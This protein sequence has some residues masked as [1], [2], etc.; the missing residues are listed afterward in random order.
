MVLYD[1]VPQGVLKEKQKVKV[2]TAIFI[3]YI[4]SGAI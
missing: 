2:E 4:N 1:P 3:N